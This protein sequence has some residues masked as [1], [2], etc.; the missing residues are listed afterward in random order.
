MIYILWIGQFGSRDS[1]EYARGDSDISI[2]LFAI[3]EQGTASRDK[4]NTSESE[5]VNKLHFKI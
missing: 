3:V 4:N 2:G 1:A 5:R